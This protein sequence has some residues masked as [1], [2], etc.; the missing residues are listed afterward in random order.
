MICVQCNKEFKAKRADAKFC[1]DACRKAFKRIKAD[2]DNNVRDN[3][4]DNVRDNGTD[5]IPPMSK[6]HLAYLTDNG[7]PEQQANPNN[8]KVVDKTSK[9]DDL[10]Y[11]NRHREHTSSYNS[12]LCDKRCIHILKT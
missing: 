3:K 4:A 7:T 10:V 2:K 12:L 11:C 8:Y 1:S 6:K 9:G 5:N